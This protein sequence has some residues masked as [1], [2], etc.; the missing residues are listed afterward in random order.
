MSISCNVLIHNLLQSLFTQ[1]HF[2][3][4]F[5]ALYNILL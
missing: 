3:A 5:C 1:P 2:N 4:S